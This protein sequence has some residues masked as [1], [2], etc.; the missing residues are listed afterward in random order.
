MSWGRPQYESQQDRLNEA[1]IKIRLQTAWK[2]ELVKQP[3]KYRLDY[4]LYDNDRLEGFCEVKRRHNPHD[5]YPTIFIALDKHLEA[6]HL[7]T[8]LGLPTFFAVHFDDGVW[9][10]DLTLAPDYISHGGRSDRN[11]PDDQEPM[12]HYAVTKLVPLPTGEQ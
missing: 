4:A 7:E 5:R 9:Y 1:A 8:H 12:A 11:D 6:K 10:L 2:C 3:K